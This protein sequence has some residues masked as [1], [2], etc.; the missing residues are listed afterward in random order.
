L[1][2]ACELVGAVAVMA[3]RSSTW[4]EREGGRGEVKAIDG[5]VAL[6]RLSRPDRW[7]HDRRTD[8][9][10]CPR[11]GNGLWPVGHRAQLVLDSETDEAN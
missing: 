8:A 6:L 2:S 11:G 7:A 3:A 1:A 9:M 4:R 5:V 10:V